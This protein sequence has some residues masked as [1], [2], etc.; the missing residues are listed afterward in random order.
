MGTNLRRGSGAKNFAKNLSIQLGAGLPKAAR[1][2][3]R[4][5]SF[6]KMNLTC[7]SPI[8][9]EQGITLVETIVGLMILVLAASSMFFALSQMNRMAS[10][11]RLAT[12]AQF[13][14]QSQIDTI[15]S[16]SPFIPQNS[17][18][19]PELAVGTTS[20]NNV[21]IYIDP[22]SNAVVASGTL[23]RAVTNI[24]VPASNEYAYQATILLDYSYRGRLFQVV[25]S[26]VRGSDQ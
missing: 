2:G 22:A 19:P 26:T 5:I 17:Q 9:S 6:A 1:L 3:N 16:D 23:S 24:S 18:I 12:A 10:E 8:Q 20:S 21:P 4:P 13:I 15:Q 7:S 11:S 25:E 14:V